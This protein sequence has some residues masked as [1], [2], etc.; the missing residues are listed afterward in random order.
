[1]R[2]LISPISSMKIVPR[3]GL[4][5]P[6]LLVAVGVGEAAAHVAEQLRLE[7]RIGNA[8]AVDRDERRAAAPAALMNQPRDNFFADAAFAGDENLGVRPRRAF[9]FFLDAADC[10]ARSDKARELVHLEWSR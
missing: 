1:M 6:A 9:D 10:F 4:L 8:R 2:R 7:E 5:E 3:V